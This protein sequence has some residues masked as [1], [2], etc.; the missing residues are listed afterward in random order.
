MR[1]LVISPS[2]FVTAVLDEVCVFGE[3]RLALRSDVRS[4]L[5]EAHLSTS[6]SIAN[7]MPACRDVDHEMRPRAEQ[8]LRSSRTSVA[9]SGRLDPSISAPVED[10]LRIRTG[11]EPLS[12]NKL[13]IRK[14]LVRAFKRPLLG[15]AD[16]IS[17]Q[18]HALV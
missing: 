17:E 15:D 2:A 9:S 14:M 16:P 13:A 3:A 4:D 6:V 18:S 8:S 1:L 5:P 11:C 7:A 12:V 10:T